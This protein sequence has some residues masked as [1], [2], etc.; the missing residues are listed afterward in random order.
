M[1]IFADDTFVMVKAKA[2]EEL[3]N[4]LY[5]TL[6][7]CDSWFN[8]NN[9]HLNVAK[10][11]L[12]NFAFK[13]IFTIRVDYNNDVLT[14]VTNTQFLGIVIDHQLNCKAHINLLPSR[15]SSFVYAFRIISRTINIETALFTCP[16]SCRKEFQESNLLTLPSILI[17]ECACFGSLNP[18]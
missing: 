2:Q 15:T 10:I 13:K 17:L 8:D 7:K 14:S 3:K 18:N 1:E 6:Q 12:I 5:R 9:L 4:Q 11:Q 16:L